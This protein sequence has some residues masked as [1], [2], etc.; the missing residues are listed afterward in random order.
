MLG[1]H[2]LITTYA[3]L[4]QATREHV[5]NPAAETKTRFSEDLIQAC[6]D[7][8]KAGQVEDLFELIPRIGVL[9]DPRFTEPLLAMLKHRDTRR[10]EFA[11]Y[12]MAAVGNGEFLDPLRQCFEEIKKLR[13][14]AAEELQVA[15]LEA[16]GAIGDDGAAEFFL[17][18]LES[19][20]P[21][22]SSNAR[23]RRAVVEAMGALAQQGGK[24][25]LDALL[26]STR[27]GDPELRAQSVAEISVAYWHRPNEIPE[28]TLQRI[29]EL[30]EDPDEGVSQSA[31]AALDS[32]ADVGCRRAERLFRS[33]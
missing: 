29:Y 6:L 12:A 16:I 27:H 10:R 31:V 18:L 14:A 9:R 4:P 26:R 5:S 22:L 24:R 13:G 19:T 30:R 8:L 1:L 17:A 21:E 7:V 28:S 2:R 32:L 33:E 11:A 25:A 20:E 15:V 3:S 23:M